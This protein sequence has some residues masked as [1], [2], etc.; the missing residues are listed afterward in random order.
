[1]FFLF[2]SGFF[3]RFLLFFYLRIFWRLSQL[4]SS[5]CFFLFF[6]WGV[7]GCAFFFLG[8]S[9]MFFFFRCVLFQ[10][11]R[12]TSRA[13]KGLQKSKRFL[14]RSRAFLFPNRLNHMDQKKHTKTPKGA[15]LFG[16]FYVTKNFQKAWHR[17]GGPGIFGTFRQ[18]SALLS[19]QRYWYPWA[20][21][22][23][24]QPWSLDIN[25][26]NQ[27]HTA[28]IAFLLTAFATK[29]FW[30][31]DKPRMKSTASQIGLTKAPQTPNKKNKLSTTH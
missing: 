21:K 9:G 5:E 15:M 19:L 26:P 3:L 4:W 8:C 17:T 18:S 12:C 7:L 23:W 27:R 6:F 22:K 20:P 24:P 14:R 1:M 16:S 13:L 11:M 30:W 2:F 25:F 29:S 28:C 10:K 31:P